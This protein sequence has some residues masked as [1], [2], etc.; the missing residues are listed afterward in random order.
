MSKGKR[1]LWFEVLVGGVSGLQVPER[2]KGKKLEGE[3][4]QIGMNEESWM[5]VILVRS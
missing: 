4:V 5:G 2:R 1:G 3:V